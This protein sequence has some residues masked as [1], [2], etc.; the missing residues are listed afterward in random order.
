MLFDVAAFLR[1]NSLVDEEFRKMEIKRKSQNYK[2]WTLG[3][4]IYEK[5]FE[6]SSKI[7]IF[8]AEIAFLIYIVFC[9]FMNTQ[10]EAETGNLGSLFI[11][12]GVL[13]LGLMIKIRIPDRVKEYLSLFLFLAA[14][15]FCVGSIELLHN[16]AVAKMQFLFVFLNYFLILTVF[17]FLYFLINHVAWTIALGTG[18]FT[19]YGLLYSFVKEFRGNGIRAADIYAVQTAANVAEGYTLNFTEQRMK[20]ILWAILF[21]VICFYVPYKNRRRDR[22]ITGALTLCF[23]SV[24]SFLVSNE[25]FLESYSVKPYLWELE[26]SEKDHGALLDFA[27][28]LPFLKVEKPDGYQREE[29]KVE[30]IAKGSQETQGLKVEISENVQKPHIIAIMNESFSDFRKL[31]DIETSR[32]FMPNWDRRQ[33]NVI[34]GFVSVPIFGGWTANSEFEFLTGFS[35]AFFPSGTIPFQNY[36]KQG[37]PSLNSQLKEQ[38]YTSIFMHPMDSSGWNRK[39]V[40]EFLD[41]DESLYLEDMKNPEILRSVVSDRGNYKIL[42]EEFEEHKEDGPVFLFNVTMQNHGGYTGSGMPNPV[43]ITNPGE[44][45]VWAEEYLTLME[46]S[47]RALE[48]LLQYFEQEEEPVVVCVFGDH[49][50]KVEEELYNALAETSKGNQAEKT[51]LKYQVPFMIYANY[52]ITEK[53]YENISLNY[54]SSLL[55][56]TAGIPLTDY[57]KYLENLFESYPVVNVYGVKNS[58]GEWFTWDEAVRFKEIKE[59]EKIQYRNL[60]DSNW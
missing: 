15:A 49:Y 33:E 21:V 28:G 39:N 11:L 10:M 4:K 8:G 19:F 56:E 40:Y 7:R 43:Q 5:F 41:F 44:N 14:P 58:Q 20:V 29:V 30:E 2:L 57:Q 50:P 34:K 47:D 45:F 25:Q 27:A 24:L 3:K 36:V 16:N 31:G 13:I 59:Y 54:L 37:T 48:E 1:V 38:G 46:E 9:L 18:I 12:N 6:K 51:S 60:F 42:K 52:D 55:C 17:M 26:A 53:Q 32:E 23:I 22:I 35:N